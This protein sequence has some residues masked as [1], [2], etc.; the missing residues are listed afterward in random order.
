M[1]GGPIARTFGWGWLGLWLYNWM[2]GLPKVN[3]PEWKA[4]YFEIFEIWLKFVAKGPIHNN[5]A[6]VLIMA[7]PRIGNKPLSETMLTRR[8][9]V[10]LG[11]DELMAA[12][13]YVCCIWFNMSEVPQYNDVSSLKVMPDLLPI[14]WITNGYRNL[15][16]N[17]SNYVVSTGHAVDPALLTHYPLK[18]LHDHNASDRVIVSDA[19][20][21][22]MNQC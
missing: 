18:M 13:L 5:P 1:I 22:H 10:A 7:W 2:N 4:V 3:F 14:I 19:P 16:G 8:I 20:S 12:M 15:G 11:G 9:Y 21:H 17:T 6:L